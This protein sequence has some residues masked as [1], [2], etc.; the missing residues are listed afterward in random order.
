MNAGLCFYDLPPDIQT[1]E[2]EAARIE[3]LKRLT[4]FRIN[5]LLNSLPASN[6]EPL[7]GGVP[8]AELA[9]DPSQELTP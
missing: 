4:L 6:H 3:L 7:R 1:S 9:G 2:I 8:G 5:F